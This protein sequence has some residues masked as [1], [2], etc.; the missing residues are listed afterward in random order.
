MA[1]I[2]R[3]Q[4]REHLWA[5]LR[6]N[7]PALLVTLLLML[8]QSL[9]AL[10]QPWLGGVLTDRLLLSQHLGT[11]L[12][13]L[14]LLICAQ[15]GLGYVIGMQMQKASG[16]L[17]ANASAE[18]YAHLQSLPLAWH[19]EHRRGDVLAL[20]TGDVYRLSGYITGILL[21]LIPLLFTLAGALVMMFRLAPVIALA[22][23]VLMPL[24]IIVLKLVGR[25]LRPLAQASAQA[26]ADQSAVAAQNLELL[27][28]I[29]A[30]AA[31]YMEAA[32]LRGK[33]NAAYAIDL[34]LARMQGAISPVV[35]VIGASTVLLLLGLAG[36]RILH[37]GMRLGEM[38][39]LFLYGTMLVSPIGRL[40]Q[41]YG[42]TLAARGSVQRL[43]D[44]LSTDPEV[45]TGSIGVLPRDGEIRYQSIDFAYPGRPT[46]FQCFDLRISAGETVALT[47]SNGAGKSTLVHMLMRLVEPQAGK[48]TIG[49]IDIR[50]FRLAALRGQIALVAQNTML[51]N[52]TIAENIGYGNT[53]AQQA[54]IERAARSARAHDFI[55]SLPDGYDTVIG[56]QGVRLSGGQKQRISLARALLMDP[57]IF[58]LD[59][60]TAM[61]DPRGEA[62][63][64]AE[65][66][67]L[68]MDHTVLLVTHRPASLALADRVLR[69]EDG[70]L[71][72]VLVTS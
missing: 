10:V 61:F 70:Q 7:V 72:E 66:R 49:G 59:E 56:D 39:S 24:L 38:V 58:I 43:L 40:A 12:W 2:L 60:A 3:K 54:D 57:A 67:D 26:W 68:L 13:L 22:M 1:D 53:D 21:P 51:F 19:Q 46:L 23:A 35:Y 28:V 31:E 50:E 9:T 62:E 65:C 4:A 5:W 63:F 71:H 42:S 14:F 25:R 69:L 30:S 41:V 27:P 44:A 18:I 16:R 29:K 45:D 36:G 8:L 33:A 15:Q 17:V 52:A 20:M 11:L 48:I 32:N 55:E 6:P 34:R 47:G 64:V 37:D